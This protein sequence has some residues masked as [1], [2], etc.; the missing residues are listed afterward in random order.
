MKIQGKEKFL[1]QLRALPD[2]MRA[3]IRKAIED[4]AEEMAETAYSFAP[5]L[6]G[7]LAF[8]IDWNLGA[9]PGGTL[10]TGGRAGKAAAAAR[11]ARSEEGLLAS[12]Y[13]G[14]GGAYYAR[15]LEFG[16]V[17]MSAQPFFFPAYRFSKGR[18]K[19]RMQRAIRSGAKKAFAK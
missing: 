8:S 11:E 1:K 7:K 4:S 6:T 18:A 16:T 10:S 13:A 15:F 12:V 14:G 19:S 2:A 3:E 9:A 17:K 5:K